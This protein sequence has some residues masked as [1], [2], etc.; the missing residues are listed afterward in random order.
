MPAE[1]RARSWFG[2]IWDIADIQFVKS[3]VCCTKYIIISALDSTSE[4]HQGKQQLHWHAVVVFNNAVA[5][6]KTKT[7]HWEKCRNLKQCIEY[8]KAKGDPPVHLS[9]EEPKAG[10]PGEIKNRFAEFTEACKTMTDRELIDNYGKMYAQ[11]TRYAHQV[12]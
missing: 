10:G 8:C 5:R 7:A 11:Y 9:G 2:T 4:A 3:L 12:R 6:P 1:D